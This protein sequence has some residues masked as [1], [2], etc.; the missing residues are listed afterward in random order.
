MNATSDDNLD[1]AGGPGVARDARRASSRL[2][3]M[4]ARLEHR[5][6]LIRN[7]GFNPQAE[8]E[9]GRLA[10]DA[11]AIRWALRRIAPETEQIGQV[12]ATLHGLD[13]HR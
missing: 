8:V 5:A 11:F 4:A 3:E 9:A 7:G 13:G 6:S 10:D 1:R 2:R 12:F